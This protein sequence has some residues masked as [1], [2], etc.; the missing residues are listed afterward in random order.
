VACAAAQATLDIVE[1][2]G[3]LQQVTAVGERLMG[4]LKDLARTS[5]LIGDVRGLGLMIGVELVRDKETKERAKAETEAVVQACYQHGLLTLPCGPNSIRFSPPL[6]LTHAE[7][8]IAFEIFAE[9]LAEVE[10][11]VFPTPVPVKSGYAMD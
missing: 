7:A 10:Q 6:I 2:P 8:D 5:R 1:E 9:A 11:K 3:F 4:R